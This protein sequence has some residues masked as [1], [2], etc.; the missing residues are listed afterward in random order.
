MQQFFEKLWITDRFSLSDL[1]RLHIFCLHQRRIVSVE[2]N[3]QINVGSALPVY[4]C[5]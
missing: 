3:V 5:V 4:K 2:R 1:I